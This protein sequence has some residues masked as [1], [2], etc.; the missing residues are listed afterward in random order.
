MDLAAEATATAAELTAGTSLH[1]ATD[2]RNVRIPGGLL[3]VREVR[4]DVLGADVEVVWDLVLIGSTGSQGLALGSLGDLASQVA[5]HVEQGVF[6]AR[7]VRDPNVSPD[8]V[9]A[10]VGTVITQPE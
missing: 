10:L 2:P 5:Q 1:V 4:Y 7:T 6:Q 3:A 9:P 8:P